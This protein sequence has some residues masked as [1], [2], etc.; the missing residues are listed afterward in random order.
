MKNRLNIARKQ[1]EIAKAGMKS[2]I[3]PQEADVNQRRATYDL[4]AAPAR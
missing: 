2:Q 1:L 4:R 3:A